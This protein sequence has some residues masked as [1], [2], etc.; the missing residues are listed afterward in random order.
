VTTEAPHHN[1][2]TCY[3]D[4]GCRKVE[5]VER[6]NIRN[7]ARLR[8]HRNGTWS[9]RYVDAEPVRQHLIALEAAG[10]GAGWVAATTGL[11]IQTV[12]DFLRSHPNRSRGRKQRTSPEIAAKI[13]AVTEESH[14]R[15]RLP[16]TGTTRRIQALVTAGW[17]LRAIASQSGISWPYMSTLLHREIV[18]A[19]THN[20]AA[21]AYARIA[22]KSPLRHGVSAAQ[23]KRARNWGAREGWPPPRYWA[24]YPD[25]IDDPHFTPEYGLTKPELRAEEARW[26]VTTAGLARTEVAARLGMTFGEVDAALAA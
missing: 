2:L 13:L 21:E 15:G 18:F 8:A 16:G 7:A 22:R 25:A 14:V 12:R 23:S 26:L 20:A 9:Q 19:S 6:Y 24:K 3:T 11:S 4:Y 1:A 17:P 5:C 10:I